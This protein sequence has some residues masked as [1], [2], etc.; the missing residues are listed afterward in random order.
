MHRYLKI[1][2]S[3]VA[4]AAILVFNML[5]IQAAEIRHHEAHE[6]GITPSECST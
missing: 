1:L 6:H 4:S 2:V 5:N 3:A